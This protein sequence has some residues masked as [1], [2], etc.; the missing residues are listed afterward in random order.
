MRFLS[1]F[2]CLIVL[3]SISSLQGQDQKLTFGFQAGP[4][5]STIKPEPKGAFEPKLR[6]SFFAGASL[7]LSLSEQW[8]IPLEL[9]FSQRG[10]QYNTE[11][12]FIVIDNQL[13]LFRGRVDYRQNYLDLAP[14]LEFWPVSSLGFAVGPYLS[15]RLGE[16]V[17]YEEVI[18]WTSTKDN[19]LFSDTDFGLSAKL[20]GY[21]GSVSVFAAFQYGLTNLSNIILTDANGQSVGTLGAKNRAVFVGVGWRI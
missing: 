10:F 4:V 2:I 17:R 13:A 8:G 9:Q 12:S 6:G 11:A 18:E 7:N 21:L 5:F 1:V 14:K 19:E 20:S 16:S 3:A 15:Y